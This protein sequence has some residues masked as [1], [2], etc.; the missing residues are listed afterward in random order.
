LASIYLP[1]YTRK[2]PKSATITYTDG[3]AYARWLDNNGIVKTSKVIKYTSEGVPVI[4]STGSTWWVKY[5][6][7]NGI[8]R[9]EKGYKSKRLTEQKKVE[10]ERR[11][12]QIRAGELPATASHRATRDLADIIEEYRQDMAGRGL[13]KRH[14]H[15]ASKM[16]SDIL[17][18]CGVTKLAD[19]D[20]NAIELHLRRRRATGLSVSSS[21]AYLIYMKM[22]F[23]WAVRMKYI[24]SS[25]IVSISKTPSKGRLMIERRS[26]SE[27]EFDNLI[28]AASTGVDCY[29]ISG[30]ERAV[31]YL[32]ASYTGLRFQELTKLQSSQFVFEPSPRIVLVASKTKNRKGGTQPIPAKIVDRVREFVKDKSGPVFGSWQCGYGACYIRHDL[33][34]AGIDF[35][36]E[37]GRRFD[38]HSLRVQFITRMALA[39][40]SIQYAQKL[41][42]LSSP[43]LLMRHY[44]KLGFDDL[45]SKVDGI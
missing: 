10:I 30:E 15:N 33:K 8:R 45:A 12:E 17:G 11:I 38:F 37:M 20:E 26:I 3:I 18:S 19:V 6:D 21:N 32:I 5:F 16:V 42:R 22:F 2:A 28:A 25:P 44:T 31:A 9:F 1:T 34:A 4:Q 24:Q 40:I 13:T 14:V 43:D 7:E 35:V 29:G 27:K 23:A 36:D 41:A 39:G